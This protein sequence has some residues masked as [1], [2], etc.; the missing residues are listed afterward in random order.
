MCYKVG[1]SKKEAQTALNSCIK[2]KKKQY[3]HEK[4]YYFCEL[5]LMWHLSSDEEYFQKE[6]IQLE[7]L[8][9]KD[10]WKELMKKEK[11]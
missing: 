10:D 9:F 6:Y 3:R 2:S 8:V 5:C 7:D 1:Y 11:E 4:R